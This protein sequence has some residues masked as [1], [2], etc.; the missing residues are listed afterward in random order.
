MP[1][2]A[3]R[4]VAEVSPQ[5]TGT[6]SGLVDFTPA[7]A[8][9]VQGDGQPPTVGDLVI[10]ERQGESLA[11]RVVATDVT[12]ARGVAARGRITSTV[13]TPSE[14]IEAVAVDALQAHPAANIPT[15]GE[16][17]DTQSGPGR[18]VGLDVPRAQ[19]TVELE[20]GDILAIAAADLM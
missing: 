19:V 13:T 14:D 9:L 2:I 1:F 7:P 3:V 11:C 6:Q 8:I 15:L 5:T 17:I 4:P 10:V 16:E 18:V 20:S 12:V